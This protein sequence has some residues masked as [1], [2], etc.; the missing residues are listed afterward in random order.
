MKKIELNKQVFPKTQ[1]E[2]VIDTQFSEL[3]SQPDQTFFDSSL[4]TV[5]DFFIIY[6]DLFF[7]IP[8]TGDINSH[9]YLIKKSSDYTGYEAENTAIQPLLE[10][11]ASLRQEN[12]ELRQQNIDLIQTSILSNR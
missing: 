8:K 9:E 7:N 1:F 11:I 6:E 10:E 5:E 12:L 4:A 3:V 2:E